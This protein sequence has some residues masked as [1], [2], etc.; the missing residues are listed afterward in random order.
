MTGHAHLDSPTGEQWHIR[1]TYVGREDGPYWG[2]TFT[3]E[4]EARTELA[5]LRKNPIIDQAILYKRRVNP[6]EETE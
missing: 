6:W 4:Q 3:D 2:Y 1:H 5:A